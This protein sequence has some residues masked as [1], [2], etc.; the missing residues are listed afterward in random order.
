[1]TEVKKIRL[2]RVAKEFNVGINTLTDHLLKKGINIDPSPNSQ[3]SPEVYAILRRTL[4]R[5]VVPQA[6]VTAYASVYSRTSS[7]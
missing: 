2:I 3:V 6:S 1:M 5:I 7:R 4:A